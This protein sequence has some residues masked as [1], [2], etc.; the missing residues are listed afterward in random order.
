MD[1][2]SLN[3]VWTSLTLKSVLISFRRK[4]DVSSVCKLVSISFNLD[5]KILFMDNPWMWPAIILKVS[6]V[7]VVGMFPQPVPVEGS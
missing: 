3:F 6:F 4:T 1:I 5:W 2:I 7:S